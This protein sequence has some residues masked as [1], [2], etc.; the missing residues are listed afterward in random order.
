MFKLLWKL[1]LDQRGVEGDGSAGDGSAGDGSADGQADAGLGVVDKGTEGD[2]GQAGDGTVEPKFGEFGDDPNEAASKLFEAYTKQKGDFDNFKTKTGL[3]ERNLGSLRKTLE[4]SGIRAVEGEDGQ[5]HLEV[6]NKEAK[7]SR[8]TE[9]HG[10]MFEPKVVEAIRLLVQDEFD[11]GFEGRDRMTKEQQ[12]KMQQF[13]AEKNQ[14]ESEMMEDFPMLDGKFKDGKP[15]NPDFNK[16]LYD[17]ATEIWENEYNKHPLKQYSA[18]RRAARELNIIPGMVKKA[19]I[20]GYEKGKGEKKILGPVKAKIVGQGVGGKLTKEEYFAL[21]EDSR[22]A[23][24]KQNAK[25]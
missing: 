9:D 3:T 11:T 1:F 19:E 14:V 2:D 8:F 21:N 4:A 20:E 25:L 17:R 24:D 5:I 13:V 18:A 6:V 22:V 12:G 23:Y 16:A 7:K 10:K 15:T